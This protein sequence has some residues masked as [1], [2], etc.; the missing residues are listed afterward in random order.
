MDPV[1][2]NVNDEDFILQVVHWVR[3]GF[4]KQNTLFSFHCLYHGHWTY[5]AV[6]DGKTFQICGGES[7]GEAALALDLDAGYTLDNWANW[8]IVTT[9]IKEQDLNE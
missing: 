3:Y 6:I 8:E 4:L 5:A 2:L 7:S 1:I 9:E